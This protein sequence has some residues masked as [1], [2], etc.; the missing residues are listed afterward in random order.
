MQTRAQASGHGSSPP[1][2][3]DPVV[4]PNA[5]RLRKFG[6]HSI[7]NMEDR[8]VALEGKDG[9]TDTHNNSVMRI[10]K[11]L[12]TMCSEFKAYYYKIVAGLETDKAAAREQVVFDEHQKKTMEFIDCLG[13]LLAKPQLDI[14]SPLFTNNRL[15]DR[16]LGSLEVLH[17]TSGEQLEVLTLEGMF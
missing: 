12:E 13:D 3:P 10:S 15:V 9:L 1:K 2:M 14:P 11:M 4:R 7:Q 8:I 5:H 6:H 17:E 16:H